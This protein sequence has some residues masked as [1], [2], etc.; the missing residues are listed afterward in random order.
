[1]WTGAFATF[2]APDAPTETG[3]ALTTIG[4]EHDRRFIVG[5][6]RLTSDPR[7]LEA[8]NTLKLQY[9]DSADV[10]SYEAAKSVFFSALMQEASIPMAR[11]DRDTSVA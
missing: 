7:L 10:D 11:P 4:S 8:Y 9:E 2:V 6:D 1:M 3:V 5:W